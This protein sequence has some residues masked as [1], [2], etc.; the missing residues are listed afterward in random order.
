M[1]AEKAI[2]P[3]L[4]AC[5]S[6]IWAGSFIAVGLTYSEIP[7]I[8]LGIF[9]FA[10]ATPLMI[11]ILFLR[12]QKLF[13]PKKEWMQVLILGL[14][15][16]TFI[17]IFQF[18]GVSLTTP[19]TASAIINTNVIL[20]ALLSRIFLKERFT[21]LKKIGIPLSFCGVFVIVLGQMTNETLVVDTLFLTGCILVLAS[22]LCWAVY[23]IVGKNLLRTYSPLQVTTNA[24]LI[25]F[26][27]YLPF[28]L[29]YLDYDY[30]HI[31]L[32]GII[33]IMYLGIF[34]SVIAYPTWSYL[35]S[36]QDAG[37]TAVFLT[38]IPFFTMILSILIIKETITPLFVIG[39][40]FIM[41]G[42]YLTQKKTI[43]QRS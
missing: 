14:T 37:Q 1:N 42:V 17:Y 18:I 6:F 5:T 23:S 3:L 2:N 15:G 19:A 33:A 31:S 12:K 36:K 29:L 27:C 10:L 38:L 34:C 39:A 9:R 41:C 43:K 13:L 22:A 32:N 28:T 7:P 24:F 11:V 40:I 4:L 20:I 35:L 25:G 26:L 16:V 21:L 8:L 30:L